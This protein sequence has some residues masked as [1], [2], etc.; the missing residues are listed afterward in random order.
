MYGRAGARSVSARGKPGSPHAAGTTCGAQPRATQRATGPDESSP[1]P[2]RFLLRAWLASGPA[3]HSRGQKHPPLCGD[4]IALLQHSGVLRRDRTA[5]DGARARIYVAEGVELCWHRLRAGALRAAGVQEGD[6]AWSSEKGCMR[7][8]RANGSTYVST[9]LRVS[10]AQGAPE[11]L[12]AIQQAPGPTPDPRTQAFPAR[13]LRPCLVAPRAPDRHTWLHRAP[14]ASV[15]SSSM[16]GFRSLMG[17]SA[18]A[19]PSDAAPAMT[20]TRAPPASR[21]GIEEA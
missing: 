21:A 5:A 11:C 3:S 20:R 10:H 15:T 6:R 1:G 9:Q 8:M 13:G 16:P 19:P 7:T 2:G 17:P 12:P 4:P 18:A 14:G